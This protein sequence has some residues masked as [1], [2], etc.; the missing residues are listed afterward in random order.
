[1]YNV[2]NVEKKGLFISVQ[3]SEVLQF[4]DTPAMVEQN[5]NIELRCT[6][7]VLLMEVVNC[8]HLASVNTNAHIALSIIT[9]YNLAVIARTTRFNIQKFYTV[10]KSRL[11]VRDGLFTLYN[12]NRLVLYNQGGVCLLRG[13]TE[14]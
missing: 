1:L 4:V 13:R 9:F 11:S 12:V 8:H 2:S 14:S 7:N 6:L 5:Q 10:L 3:A